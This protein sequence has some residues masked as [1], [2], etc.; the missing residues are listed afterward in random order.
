[1]PAEETTHESWLTR[2]KEHLLDE[3]YCSKVTSKSLATAQRFLSY[4][5]EN[6]LRIEA[7]RP[8]DV[9]AFLTQQ[10]DRHQERH[11]HPPKDSRA[12][13][14]PHSAAVHILLRLGQVPWPPHE[15]GDAT[16]TFRQ[17]LCDEYT[18][19]LST[20]QALAPST[21]DLRSACARD[22][23]R[24]LDERCAEDRLA[25]LT[26]A[27]IDGYIKSRAPRLRRT[28][29]ASLATRLRS[30]LRFLHDHKWI[31]TDLARAVFGPPR[32]MF[33]DIPS[34]IRPEDVSA[35]LKA[36][37][38][39]QTP[40]GLRDYAILMLLS[41]YGLRAGEV[42]GLRLEDVD[43]RHDRLRIR[44]SKTGGEVVLPLLVPVGEAVLSFIQKA[45]PASKAREIFIRM[46]APY[47]AM[48]R[49]GSLYNLINRRM[50][51]AGVK[52]AGKHGPHIFRHAFAVSLLRAGVSVKSIGDLLGHRSADS[53]TVYLKL[54]T[55]DLRAVGLN[56][57]GEVNR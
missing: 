18:E 22:L 50:Q 49:G 53:T 17:R 5:Q 27:D 8:V 16:A 15:Q 10:L 54:A 39:D 57:P 30:F 51:R 14:R 20:C 40:V 13:C 42:T 47:R 55:E 26:T 2:L 4:L 41:A 3:R 52:P 7:A 24:W 23:L 1:L 37:R 35:V 25:N 56:L 34:L 32:Y 9:Q 48:R 12:W 19:W 36:A 44:H 29:C 46:H 11:G 38:K 45:R 21:I 43:W 28:T 33:E 31:G 6:K